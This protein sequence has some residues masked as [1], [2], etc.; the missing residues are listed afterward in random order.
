[1]QINTEILIP[2]ALQMSELRPIIQ[3][4]DVIPEI[5]IS[6][7]CKVRWRSQAQKQA[8]YTRLHGVQIA[9]CLA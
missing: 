5:K 3:T 9:L 4:S 8:R 2:L 7:V 1:M 6:T